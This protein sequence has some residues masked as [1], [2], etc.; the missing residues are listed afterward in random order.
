MRR[1]S[2][3]YFSHT[4]LNALFIQFVVSRGKVFHQFNRLL[5]KPSATSF[6][7]AAR[8]LLSSLSFTMSYNSTLL[9]SAFINNFHLPLRTAREGLRSLVCGYLKTVSFRPYSQKIS[10]DLKDGFPINTDALFSPSPFIPCGNF[11]PARL[12]KL[13]SKSAAYITDV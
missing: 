9:P 4:N 6:S 1:M 10:F 2:S 7:L 3:D 12:Q 5:V 13:G 11:T 8:L